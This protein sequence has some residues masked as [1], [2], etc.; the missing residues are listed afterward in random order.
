MPFIENTPESLL[1]RTDSLDPK[2]TCHGITGSGRPCR[3]PLGE[4]TL[5][6]PQLRKSKRAPTDLAD[7]TLYCWQH[8]DQAARRTA[9]SPGPRISHSG[10][11]RSSIDTLT[12]RLGL[13]GIGDTR[14]EGRPAAPAKKKTFTFCCCFTIPVPTLE[15]EDVEL[16]PRPR[17][18]PIQPATQYTP[19][20]PS[21]LNHL[22]PSSA[23]AGRVSTSSRKSRRSHHAALI[24]STASAET[25]DQL[26]S[27]LAKPIS[28]KDDPGYIY[29][30]WLIPE[31]ES[32]PSPRETSRS[33]LSPPASLPFGG[34]ERR[35]SDVVSAFANTAFDFWEDL[36]NDSDEEGGPTA[37]RDVPRNAERDR[38][39]R[40]EGK[41][42]GKK[43]ILLKIGRAINVQR[44]LNEWTRQ[45]GYVLRLIRYYPY[46]PSGSPGATPRKMPHSHKV[47][48]LIHIELGGAGLRVLD[49]DKCDACGREHREWFEVEATRNAIREVD[50]IVKR[51]VIWDEGVI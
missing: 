4:S 31:S 30:F 11:R 18:Q 2:T 42:E 33:L 7:P 40:V 51:W 8:R 49:G 16:P 9:S 12:E 5:S 41:K 46:I 39:K 10:R 43:T 6:A 29:M 17:P 28:A 1:G 3:R 19:G 50:D 48:R 34:R 25:T 44:R 22:K 32:E 45:C 20:R 14:H 27:E 47:E 23:P 15:E 21:S 36:A 37:G 24:P 13:T 35:P 38:K 26:L